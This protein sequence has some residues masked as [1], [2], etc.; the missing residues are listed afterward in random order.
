M[1][2]ESLFGAAIGISTPWFVKSIDF[3]SE[4]K[5][6]DVVIDFVKGSLDLNFIRTRMN[7][8]YKSVAFSHRLVSFLSVDWI[9]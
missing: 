7:R 4:L 6:L 1:D 8:K 2:M 3:D 9:Y 5:R